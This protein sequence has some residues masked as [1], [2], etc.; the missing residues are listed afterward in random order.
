MT[1]RICIKNG[2]GKPF[3]SNQPERREAVTLRPFWMRYCPEHRVTGEK[4][5][6]IVERTWDDILCP[7]CQSSP[8]ACDRGL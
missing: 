7:E 3:D 1:T 6:P 4:Y 5:E 2:C 8:C